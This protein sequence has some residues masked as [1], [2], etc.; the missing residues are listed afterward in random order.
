MKTIIIIP[1]YNEEQTI[2]K[3]IEEAK[4]QADE[5]IVIDDG[6][7]DRTKEIAILKNAIVYRHDINLGLG[8]ALVT[9]FE[10]SLKHGADITITLDAD[11]Q[12]NP[13]DV[14]KIVKEIQ[15]GAEFVIGSRLTKYSKEM[16]TLRYFYNMAGN[17]FT[18]LLYG[19]WTSDSQSGLRGFS[20]EALKKINLNSQKMEVSS[21]FFREA[22]K[23]N[24]KIKEIPIKPVYT[25]Y[26]LSKGQ[27]FTTGVKTLIRLILNKII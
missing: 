27:G 15:N 10:A 2:G 5:V 8:A 25:E 19:I 26:S 12:H 17:V 13:L 22:K 20:R 1:A 9:G 4:K 3:V 24:L 6:S 16:P 21:E 23:N 7:K 18:F 14:P 11:G